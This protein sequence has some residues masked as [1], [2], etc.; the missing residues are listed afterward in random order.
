LLACVHG[1]DQ[2]FMKEWRR[3]HREA[4]LLDPVVLEAAPDSLDA[5]MAEMGTMLASYDGLDME[6]FVLKIMA[7]VS[8]H[9]NLIAFRIQAHPLSPS[10]LLVIFY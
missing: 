2:D 6:A 3:G 5:L 8:W 10:L 1:H 7:M 9:N 4:T